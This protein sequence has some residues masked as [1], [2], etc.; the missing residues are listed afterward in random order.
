MLSRHV[1][2]VLQHRLSLIIIAGAELFTGNN[3]VFAVGYMKQRVTLADVLKIF[4]HMLA[5]L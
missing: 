2:A 1:L 4:C 5:T 3:M